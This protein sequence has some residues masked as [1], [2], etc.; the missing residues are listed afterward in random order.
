MSSA[1]AL[2]DCRANMQGA[3][4]FA[5]KDERRGVPRVRLLFRPAAQD[6]AGVPAGQGC[7]AEK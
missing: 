6:A 1:Q 3:C 7:P 5:E 4:A 2:F